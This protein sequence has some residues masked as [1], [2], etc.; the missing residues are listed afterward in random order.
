MIT[1]D[2]CSHP[3]IEREV[4]QIKT[5]VWNLRIK[6]ARTSLKRQTLSQLRVRKNSDRNTHSSRVRAV[7]A[8]KS[9][10]SNPISPKP[11]S[12]LVCRALQPSTDLPCAFQHKPSTPLHQ[13][14]EYQQPSPLP[15]Q[16]SVLPGS[17]WAT[18]RLSILINNVIP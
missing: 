3:D 17:P 1:P 16:P 18:R 11:L 12:S 14:K 2:L 7:N 5:D 9:D 15:D 13:R 10:G 8:L 6:L 4:K